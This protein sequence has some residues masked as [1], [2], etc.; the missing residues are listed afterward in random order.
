[1]HDV[2]SIAKLLCLMGEKALWQPRQEWARNI[3]PGVTL[4]FRLGRGA[5]TYHL[6]RDKDHVIVLG[7][8]C[9]ADQLNSRRTAC[10]WLSAKEITKRKYFR[11]QLLPAE[12]LVHI[13]CHEFAHFV[14]VLLGRR[15]KGSVH[16]KEFYE[17]LDRV[18]KR[19]HADHL[20]KQFRMACERQNI[21]LT[22]K[23][24]PDGHQRFMVGDRVISRVKSGFV[25]GIVAKVESAQV[26]IE[27]EVNGNYGYFAV[28]PRF[29]EQDK[30]QH[31]HE[32]EGYF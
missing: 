14:Q 9:L 12:L 8:K 4:D 16:N 23:A 31:R 3:K 5:K 28:E 22:F 30:G 25:Q 24:R 26:T 21:S 29:L 32:I 18:H 13:L 19:G 11:G 10:K 2:L 6:A 27:A 20:L 17:I 1:M 7:V 15:Y